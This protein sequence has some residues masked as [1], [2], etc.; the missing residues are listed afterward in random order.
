MFNDNPN[1]CKSKKVEI[2]EV[3]IDIATTI[4]ERQSCKNKNNTSDVNRTPR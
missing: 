1:A 4:V 3:G 2:I